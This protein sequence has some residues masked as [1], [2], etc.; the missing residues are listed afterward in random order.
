MVCEKCERALAKGVAAPDPWKDG[1]RNTNDTGRKIGENKA[2]S[3]GFATRKHNPYAVSRCIVCGQSVSH[4]GARYCQPCAYSKG[5]CAVCGKQVLDTRFYAMGD[6]NAGR[7]TKVYDP[8]EYHPPGWEPPVESAP[9]AAPAEEAAASAKKRKRDNTQRTVDEAVDV[10]R[11]IA[12]V[13]A[14]GSDW[15]FDGGT[16]LYFSL[17]HQAYF[18]ARSQLYYVH[19]TWTPQLQ[20]N[21]PQAAATS[22]AVAAAPAEMR[23]H[24]SGHPREAPC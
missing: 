2:L 9:A 12:T 21:P 3:K 4:S 1:S 7:R 15:K 10:P 22:P 6:A 5:V 17:A 19:G 18:D 11:G 13:G 16:G 24:G 8:K 20:A 14:S 23:E